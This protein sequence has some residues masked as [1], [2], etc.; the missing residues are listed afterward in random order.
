MPHASS[1]DTVQPYFTGGGYETAILSI[2][3]LLHAALAFAKTTDLGVVISIPLNGTDSP[4]YTFSDAALTDS[5]SDSVTFTLPDAPPQYAPGSDYFA[6]VI[7]S[8]IHNI[9]PSTS[10]TER[11]TVS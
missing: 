7:F 9:D 11:P 6:K 8:S 5:F 2:V 10:T 1:S 3:L 4:A